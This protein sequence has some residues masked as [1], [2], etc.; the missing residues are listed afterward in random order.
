MNFR[1]PYYTMITM[2]QE[3]FQEFGQVREHQNPKLI[4]TA[5]FKAYINHPKKQVLQI[6]FAMA[7]QCEL[8]N[9][10]IRALWT[11]GS[12]NLF[13][14]ALYHNSDKNLYLKTFKNINLV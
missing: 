3:R 9:E 8:P 12:V 7:Y 11:R 5:E 6:D 4:Q 13:T 1:E 14:C 2:L 10:T